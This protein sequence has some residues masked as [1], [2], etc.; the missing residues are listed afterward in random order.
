M[1]EYLIKNGANIHALDDY[2]LMISI[3][4]EYFPIIE[5]LVEI[6]ISRDLSIPDK[7]ITGKI[8]EVNK[9]LI[10]YANENQYDLFNLEIVKSV[11]GCKS[12]RNI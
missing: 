7:L 12:A 5:F 11:T 10:L 1:V 8:N 4:Y 6:Y 2:A 9:L 3:M